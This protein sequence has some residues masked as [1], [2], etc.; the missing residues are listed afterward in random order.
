MVDYRPKDNAL[1]RG[2]LS[3]QDLNELKTQY[4]RLTDQPETP[5]LRMSWAKAADA[6][7]AIEKHLAG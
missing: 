3:G 1:G 4:K 7:A 5:H 2:Y 6:L